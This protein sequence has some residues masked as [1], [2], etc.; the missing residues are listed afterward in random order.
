MKTDIHPYPAYKPSGVPRLGDVPE[1]WK[2]RR[3]RTVSEMRVSNVDKHTREG[4]IPV[5]LCNYTDVYKNDHIQQGIAFMGATASMDEPQDQEL[6]GWAAA[7]Q[8]TY[9]AA[10]AFDHPQARQRRRVQQRLER[11]LLDLC[12][13]YLPVHGDHRISRKVERRQVEGDH[14]DREAHAG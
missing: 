7:V 8:Q 14:G 13:P 9:L 3:L 4:E 10:A 1:H 12:R 2:I 6:A 5:R 11:K